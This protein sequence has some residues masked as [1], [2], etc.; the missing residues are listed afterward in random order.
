MCYIRIKSLKSF[1]LGAQVYICLFRK[2]KDVDASKTQRLELNRGGLL[3]TLA[4]DPKHLWHKS[5][6][7]TSDSYNSTVPYV[8]FSF[9]DNN[10]FKLFFF[11]KHVIGFLLYSFQEIVNWCWF[12]SDRSPKY[13]VK[14]PLLWVCK[15]LHKFKW[16]NQEL[17]WK[18]ISSNRYWNSCIWASASCV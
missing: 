3:K 15:D 13:T 16:S 12:L 18:A 1:A 5:L 2:W 4:T 6:K 17:K 10:Y 11:L 7:G 9:F 8:T 14:F